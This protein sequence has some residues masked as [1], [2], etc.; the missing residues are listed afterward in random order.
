MVT[1]RRD[2]ITALVQLLTA[3]DVL[4]KE[5]IKLE[6]MKLA[7]STVPSLVET[8][9][10]IEWELHDGL[11]RAIIHTMALATDEEI[12]EA[13]EV[14]DASDAGKSADVLAKGEARFKGALE[15]LA[16]A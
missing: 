13:I 16:N 9:L 3:H 2:V 12:Y 5:L 1:M 7:G 10:E 11:E 4:E 15:R 6:R 8:Q 14:Y